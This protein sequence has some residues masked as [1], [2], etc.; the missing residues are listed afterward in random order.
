[1]LCA[2]LA[3]LL[4]LLVLT[5]SALASHDVTERLSFGPTGGNGAIAANYRG[6][7]SDGT[8]VFFQTTEKLVSADTDSAIDLYER[9]G[10]T[11]TLISTG[12]NGGNGAFAATYSGASQDGTKV[13][14]RTSEKLVSA[15]TDNAIDIYMRSAGAAPL[16]FPG[17]AAANREPT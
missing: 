13:F 7:S 16:I 14:L 4:S 11:T 6:I 10:A 15:D 17:P 5:A 1:M 8:R 12:P 2:G 3:A 9:S